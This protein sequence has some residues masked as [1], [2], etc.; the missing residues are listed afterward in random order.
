LALLLVERTW[1]GEQALTKQ[2]TQQGAEKAGLVN[3]VGILDQHSPRLGGIGDQ[4]HRPCEQAI[5]PNASTRLP[6]ARKERQTIASN[7]KQIAEDG[8]A[9][10]ARDRLWH[11]CVPVS[12]T[13][14]DAEWS[15]SG[16]VRRAI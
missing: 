7:I 4:D 13:Q 3:G 8:Q 9:R 1:T 5:L 14:A 6:H 10:R 12:L 2:R 16:G 15:C 11:G